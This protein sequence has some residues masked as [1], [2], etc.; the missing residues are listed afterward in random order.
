MAVLFY[1]FKLILRYSGKRAGERKREDDF[2]F[3]LYTFC[4][5][6]FGFGVFFSSNEHMLFC[7]FLKGD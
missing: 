3:L 2:H 7:A 4:I 1:V 6:F 5:E